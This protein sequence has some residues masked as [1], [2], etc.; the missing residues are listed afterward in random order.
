MSNKSSINASKTIK[1]KRKRAL[2]WSFTTRPI[3]EQAHAILV[4]RGTFEELS[5][6]DEWRIH[7][8]TEARGSGFQ[9]KRRVWGTNDLDQWITLKIRQHAQDPRRTQTR[10]GFESG[11]VTALNTDLA[12]LLRAIT[13]GS[14]GPAGYDPSAKDESAGKASKVCP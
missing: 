5:P 12:Q 9:H 7:P 4:E 3:L 8:S 10:T 11:Q 14:R 1:L 2:V 6:P 13:Q